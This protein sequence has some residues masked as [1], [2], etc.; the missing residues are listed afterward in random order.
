MLSLEALSQLQGQLVS[1]V[2]VASLIAYANT[3]PGDLRVATQAYK[4]IS[5]SSGFSSLFKIEPN[6]IHREPRHRV[7]NHRIIQGAQVKPSLSVRSNFGISQ[8]L[9]AVKVDIKHAGETR[10]LE[11]VWNAEEQIYS[12]DEF[13]SAENKLG[14]TLKFELLL[15]FFSLL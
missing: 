14:M 4:A 10:T 6:Y 12:S 3:L 7:V 15:N 9:L 1:S 8:S 13:F 2:D 5:K 11:L